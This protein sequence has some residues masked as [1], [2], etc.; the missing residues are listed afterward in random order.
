MTT[1]DVCRHGILSSNCDICSL[2]QRVRQLENRQITDTTRLEFLLANAVGIYLRE[3]YYCTLPTNT[4]EAIDK[5]M[6]VR[7]W[8]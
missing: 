3:P 4:R 1:P 5:M 6:M 2:V 7:F 8:K